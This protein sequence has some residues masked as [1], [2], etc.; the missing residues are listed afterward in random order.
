MK[1]YLLW[2]IFDNGIWDEYDLT[3][4]KAFKTEATANA[5]AEYL[6]LK[7]NEKYYKYVIDEIELEE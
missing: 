1:I 4:I 2:K 6:R 3:L 7:E 5:Y